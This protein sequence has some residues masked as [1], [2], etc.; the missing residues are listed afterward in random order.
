MT[1]KKH[2]N[3]SKYYFSNTS[4]NLTQLIKQQYYRSKTKNKLYQ[5]I[6]RE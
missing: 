1:G 5:N 4:Y 6:D 3:M 2:A